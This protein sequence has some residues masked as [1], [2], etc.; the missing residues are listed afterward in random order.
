[1]SS[2][3]ATFDSSLSRRRRRGFTLIEL[4]VAIGI[5]LV[6][7]MMIIGF[8][9]G[10]LTISRTG[11]ARGKVYETAQIVHRMT[12]E[13]LSQVAAPSPHA[14]GDNATGSFLVTR[15]PYGRQILCFTRAWGEQLT[16]LAGYDSGRTS[17]GQGYGA[18]FSGRNVNDALLPSD[19]D[20]EVCW[21]LEP[22]GRDLRLMRAVESP[23]GLSFGLIDRVGRWLGDYPKAEPGSL[24]QARAA[25]EIEDEI[26]GATDAGDWWYREPAYWEP[27]EQAADNVLAFVVECWDD[28]TATWEAGPTGPL[29]EWSFSARMGDGLWPLPWAVRITLVVAADAPLDAALELD[30]VLGLGDTFV[31]VDGDTRNYPDGGTPDAY[32]CVNGEL[33]AYGAKGSDGFSSCVRGAFGTT[34]REH[35]TGSIV[36]AGEAFSWVIQLP[37]S[38]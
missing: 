18:A 4:M 12:R 2:R 21:M 36:R 37:V 31:R 34:E 33:I 19:G 1:M 17:T 10:A 26:V 22:Y 7:G 32:L 5:L 29:T 15:D 14:D 28:R 20:I 35:P 3:D 13:D 24:L 9:R 27:F 30:G 6:L 11:Q 8:W 38:R 23:P 25:D 16:T